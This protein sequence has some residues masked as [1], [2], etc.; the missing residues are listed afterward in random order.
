MLLILKDVDEFTADNSILRASM[1]NIRARLLSLPEYLR[2]VGKSVLRFVFGRGSPKEPKQRSDSEKTV[3][4]SFLKNGSAFLAQKSIFLGPNVIGRSFKIASH[5]NMTLHNALV[6]VPDAH[7]NNSR[8]EEYSLFVKTDTGLVDKVP[9]VFEKRSFKLGH[10]HPDPQHPNNPNS[11]I[12]VNLKASRF[13]TKGFPFALPIKR[14]ITFSNEGEIPI[15]ITKILFENGLHKDICLEISKIRP[16]TLQPSDVVH[17]TVVL[18]SC[19][20]ISSLVKTRL[21]VFTTSQII[22]FELQVHLEDFH[23]TLSRENRFVL[24]VFVGQGLVFVFLAIWF[25]I[26]MFKHKKKPDSTEVQFLGGQAAFLAKEVR[27]EKL[28]KFVVTIRFGTKKRGSYRRQLILDELNR[29]ETQEN[30]LPEMEL[31]SEEEQ[32]EESALRLPLHAL[33]LPSETGHEVRTIEYSNTSLALVNEIFNDAVSKEGANPHDKNELLQQAQ[34][35]DNVNLTD[36]QFGVIGDRFNA[37]NFSRLSPKANK[38]TSLVS[39]IASK[40]KFSF[41]ISEYRGEEP[42]LELEDVRMEPRWPKK[43]SPS[44]SPTSNRSLSEQAS[45]EHNDLE[46]IFDYEGVTEKPK[47]TDSPRKPKFYSKEELER[48]EKNIFEPPGLEEAKLRL[49]S[50]IRGVEADQ[51]L[52]NEGLNKTPRNRNRRLKRQSE[53]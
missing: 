45:L 49:H 16:V 21:I 22:P 34:V 51:F 9:I 1:P 40:S 33:I 41:Q 17:I 10:V 5:S 46:Q 31:E 7:V 26:W 38:T 2:T 27:F 50:I 24:F 15:R 3:F 6:F 42:F 35:A 32:V 48:M 4:I 18:H 53:G 47:K 20:K 30:L 12:F 25:S 19:R 23:V 28:C 43:H 14:R 8:E 29:R 11:T 39:P 52:V 37:M 36:N 44:R 13:T